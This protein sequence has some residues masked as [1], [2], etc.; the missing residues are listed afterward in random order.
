LA[1]TMNVADPSLR[2]GWRGEKRRPLLSRGRPELVLCLALV[3]H[4]AITANVPM[5]AC[6]DWL[7]EL[8]AWLVIEFP[9]RD[10]PI[11]ERLLAARKEGTHADYERA[12][13][14]RCL[15]DAFEVE[16]CA[17]LASGTRLL[18]LARPRGRPVAA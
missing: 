13:F 1:L 11:V 18:Y 17:S 12:A 7:A 14:G 15:G 2:L 4:V 16:R 8:G 3:V 6:I 9:A 10:N 5:R